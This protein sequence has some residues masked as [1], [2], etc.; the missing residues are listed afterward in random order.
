MNHPFLPEAMRRAGLEAAEEKALAMFDAIER[1]G[2]IASG[3]TEKQLDAEIYELARR[4]FGVEKHWHKRVV[5]AGPNTV[6]I[7][8]DDPPVHTIAPNDIVY[9]DLGPVFEAKDEAWEADIGR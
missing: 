5:R 7:F 1:E 4:D 9:L 6:C 3:K 8:S 2:L